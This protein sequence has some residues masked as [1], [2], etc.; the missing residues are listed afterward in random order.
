MIISSHKSFRRI[1][2]C[3]LATSCNALTMAADATNASESDSSVSESIKLNV[4]PVTCVALHKGQTCHKNLR[5]SWPPLP[6]GR[7]C[8][9]ASDSLHPLRCWQDTAKINLTT[10]YSSATKVRY[11]LRKENSDIPLAHAVVK[12]A[13]V[14]R[15]SRRSSSGWRLF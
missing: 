6:A 2:L 13:W 15:T 1:L 9:H 8:L 11:E 3:V 5:F 10:G 7:Y 4:R 12:T 14:Y